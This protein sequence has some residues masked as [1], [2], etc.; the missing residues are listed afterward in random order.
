MNHAGHQPI[1]KVLITGGSGFIGTHLSK[2]LISRGYDVTIFDKEASKLNCRII[3]GDIRNSVL[4]ENAIQEADAVFHLAATVSIPLCQEIP[5]E[6]YSNN[7]LAT[8]Q[9]AKAI[10]DK[11][12][13]FKTKTR[14]V[15][16]SSAAVYG[17][18]G[19][20][21]I[22]I[23][24]TD[25]ARFP[26]SHYA[27][28]KLASEQSLKVF[29]DT[30][31]LPSVVFRFF[32]VYGSGQNPKSPYSGVI[33]LFHEKIRNNKN[34]TIFG[35]GNFTR[36]FIDVDDL[37]EA[38]CLSLTLDLAQCNAEPINLGSG[39]TT[40]INELART[41]LKIKKSNL[42][43]EHQEPRV[44]DVHYS[45]ASIERA[46]AILNWTPRNALESGLIQMNL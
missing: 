4:L 7:Q 36:D 11:N 45:L 12:K 28:Q 39:I 34:L 40:T 46:K 16:A 13:I 33:T 10:L 42:A 35:D 14:I 26:L 17:A 15:F 37:T 3:R 31:G 30:E 2:K 38:L 23:H 32:N 5:M 6:S 21:G 1:K 8:V 41:L 25:T 18:V 43:I 44:G 22:P 24:E 20:S 9:V 27:S 19:K 29:H